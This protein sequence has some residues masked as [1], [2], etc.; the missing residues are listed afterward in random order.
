MDDI[1]SSTSTSVI[2]E[3]KENIA[4]ALR[5]AKLV[6][7]DGNISAS[8]IRALSKLCK[9]RNVPC[10]FEPTTPQKGSRVVE[11][12]VLHDMK[13][14]SPN[15]MELRALARALGCQPDGFLSRTA[16]KVL[17]S[18]GGGKIGQ[19]LLVTRGAQGVTRF[20]LEEASDD[21][22]L[23]EKT[24][25]AIKV[26]NVGNTTGAGD[27]FAGRCVAALATGVDE[28]DAIVL[29]LHAAADCC[30]GEANVSGGRAKL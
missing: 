13:Y 18:G 27:S 2:A 8:D 6:C 21:F 25:K 1:F 28:D 11:A 15:E 23:V 14:I 12:G 3:S 5:S 17:R 16:E 29:G 19:R 9:Q 24:F 7:L 30:R 4:G 26:E 22:R 20:H 10:W